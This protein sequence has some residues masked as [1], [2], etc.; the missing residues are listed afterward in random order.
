MLRTQTKTFSKEIVDAELLHAKKVFEKY[1]L[2]KNGFLEF[3][4][5]IPMLRD[6]YKVMGNQYEPTK[7]DVTKYIEMMDQDYDGKISQEEYEIFVLKAL[8]NRGINL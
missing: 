6:T 8:Q 1:D 7:T 3:E 4:E 2:N 5:V